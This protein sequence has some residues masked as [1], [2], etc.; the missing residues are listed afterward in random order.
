[1]LGFDV[2]EANGACSQPDLPFRLREDI[3]LTAPD[4]STFYTPMSAE[5][6]TTYPFSDEFLKTQSA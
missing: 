6:Y 5:G 2:C 4:A 3:P 1:M